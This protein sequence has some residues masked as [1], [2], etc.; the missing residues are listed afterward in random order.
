MQWAHVD[1]QHT[2]MSGGTPRN[3]YCQ[4]GCSVRSG[5]AHTHCTCTCEYVGSS[6][7]VDSS[8]SVLVKLSDRSSTAESESGTREYAKHLFCQW[9]ISI[10]MTTLARACLSQPHTKHCHWGRIGLRMFIETIAVTTIYTI[11]DT[12]NEE[13]PHVTIIFI[14]LCTINCTNTWPYE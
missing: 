3:L 5:I 14:I 12:S 4:Y 6:L 8:L 7:E 1:M 11:K 9:V 2:G 10:V 13:D